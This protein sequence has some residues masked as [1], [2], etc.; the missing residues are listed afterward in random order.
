MYFQIFNV[1]K[2]L[3]N[4]CFTWPQFF[5]SMKKYKNPHVNFTY[6]DFFFHVISS[7]GCH[8]QLNAKK[9]SEG[10][11]Y[12]ELMEYSRVFF[13]HFL[14]LHFIILNWLNLGR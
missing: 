14:I 10:S 12:S 1:P 6:Q 2:G 11:V 8:Q 4:K 9:D 3:L 7:A 5:D 13:F